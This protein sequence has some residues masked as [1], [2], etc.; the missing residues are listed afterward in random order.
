MK[1]QHG[2]LIDADI[3]FFFLID[4]IRIVLSYICKII[5]E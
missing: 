4:L 5:G 1:L 2:V 3:F